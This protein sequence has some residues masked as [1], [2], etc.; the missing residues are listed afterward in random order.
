[1]TSTL[2]PS[3]LAGQP[4]HAGHGHSDHAG[5]SHGQGFPTIHYSYPIRRPGRIGRFFQWLGMHMPEWLAPVGVLLCVAGGVAYTL[6][7]D[8]TASDAE[9][10]P[11]CVM[12]MLTGFDCPGCGGTR[13]AWY[14]LHGNVSAAARHHAIFVFAVP[15]LIWMYIAWAG[16]R[17]F[18][19]NLPQ[20]KV[21]PRAIGIFLAV[22][23]VW[24]V[25]R[26]LPWS[27]FTSLY[28]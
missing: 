19:W 5:H 7:M 17:I 16:K 10:R 26:N 18:G 25:A 12:K 11:T 23:G 3:A 27:P 6:L 4:T 2:T 9:S 28:V 13:A 1:V 14:L 21:G 24:S 15:F 8:P 22:W 20:L